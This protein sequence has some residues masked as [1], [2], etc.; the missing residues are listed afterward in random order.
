MIELI[1]MRTVSAVVLVVVVVAFDLLS[2][3]ISP[4]SFYFFLLVCFCFCFCLLGWLAG[5]F[6]RGFVRAQRGLRVLQ[7]SALS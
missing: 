4:S 1:K 5:W 2:L 6:M 7:C 3:V